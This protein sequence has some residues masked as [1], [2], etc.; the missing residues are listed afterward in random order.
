MAGGL[1][2]VA[3]AIVLLAL[4]A[5]DSGPWVVRALMFAV[6]AAMACG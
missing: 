3:T 2:L 6:G 1:V 5:L 4:V